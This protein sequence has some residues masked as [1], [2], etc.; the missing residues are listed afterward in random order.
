MLDYAAVPNVGGYQLFDTP[1]LVPAA[2]FRPRQTH[3]ACFT[4][5]GTSRAF[6]LFPACIQYVVPITPC[7][8]QSRLRT[9]KSSGLI[10]T[11]VCISD[12]QPVD[13]RVFCS[14][15]RNLTWKRKWRALMNVGP[16]CFKLIGRPLP[17]LFELPLS[18]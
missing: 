8:Q 18:F 16:A 2:H 15:R 3:S 13:I 4:N 5:P 10:R 17:F 7:R 11:T 14:L 6:C 9:C 1:Y 12:R